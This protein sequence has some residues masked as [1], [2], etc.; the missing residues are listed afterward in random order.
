MY[1]DGW[2]HTNRLDEVTEAN[3]LLF[4]LWLESATE[5]GESEGR[6]RA[7]WPFSE[8]STLSKEDSFFLADS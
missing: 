2:F 6:A 8:P 5:S 4:G 3:R 7:L 1:S